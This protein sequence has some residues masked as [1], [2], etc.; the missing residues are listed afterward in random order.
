MMGRQVAKANG[1]PLFYKIKFAQLSHASFDK[2]IYGIYFGK[3][4][5]TPAN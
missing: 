2:Q 4:T 5:I 1:G 3:E